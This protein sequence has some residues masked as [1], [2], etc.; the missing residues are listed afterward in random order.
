MLFTN[1]KTNGIKMH[2]IG[3]IDAAFILCIFLLL[4]YFS[5]SIIPSVVIDHPNISL[6]I[7]FILYRF[8]GIFIFDGTIGMKALK[9]ILRNE[10]EEPLSLTEIILAS[11]FILHRGVDYYSRS[12]EKSKN[13]Y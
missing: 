4:F 7:G 11:I 6:F 5:S 3:L 8:I 1:K 13:H 10:N 2:A 9:V 12:F